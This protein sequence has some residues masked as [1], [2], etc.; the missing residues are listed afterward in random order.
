MSSMLNLAALSGGLRVALVCVCVL[1]VGCGSDGPT[2]IPLTG[3]V[4]QG[5]QPVKLGAISLVPK[6]GQRGVAANS[7]IQDGRYHF[8]REDGPGPGSY[9]VTIMVSLT[10]E[11]LHKRRNEDRAEQL[12]WEFDIKLPD[13]GSAT[14]DFR[15][16]T[17]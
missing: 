14:E 12:Q 9:H 5:D 11:E 17:K 16:E 1:S 4:T 6:E 8:T 3:K 10:K 7:A 15:L 13:S 2:R